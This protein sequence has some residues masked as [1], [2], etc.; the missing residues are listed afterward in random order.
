M[1]HEDIKTICDT[2]ALITF[3]LAGLGFGAYFMKL[4]RGP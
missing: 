1:T 4:L 3:T 2:A